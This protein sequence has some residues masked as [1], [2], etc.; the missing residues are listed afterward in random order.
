M[1]RAHYWANEMLS[2][3]G[4]N[5]YRQIGIYLLAAEQQLPKRLQGFKTCIMW[6]H[7]KIVW[8]WFPEALSSGFASLIVMVDEQTELSVNSSKGENL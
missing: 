6:D 5:A 8:I 2:L 4:W 3:L 7:K 1:K